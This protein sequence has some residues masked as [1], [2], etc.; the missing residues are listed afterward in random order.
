MPCRHV[1]TCP[2]CGQ[3]YDGEFTLAEA[4]QRFTDRFREIRQCHES[5]ERASEKKLREE[6]QR[7][8]DSYAVKLENA[9]KI[10]KGAAKEALRKCTRAELIEELARREV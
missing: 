7:E 9:D 4:V 2:A 6:F 3:D 10:V 5:E 8:R 1:S